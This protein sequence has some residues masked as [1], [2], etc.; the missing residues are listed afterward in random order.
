MT[1]ALLR[2]KDSTATTWPS[3]QETSRRFSNDSTNISVFPFA[4][5]AGICE[6]II[7]IEIAPHGVPFVNIVI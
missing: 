2:G 5:G 1:L 3:E 7:T 4:G 6:S